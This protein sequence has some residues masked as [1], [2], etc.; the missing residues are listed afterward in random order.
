MEELKISGLIFSW[1]NNLFTNFF[2]WY[3]SVSTLYY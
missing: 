2:E 1:I 3:F